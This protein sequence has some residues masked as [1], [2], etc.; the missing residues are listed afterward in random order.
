MIHMGLLNVLINRLETS[1][2]G[3]KEIHNTDGGKSRT[4]SARAQEDEDMEIIFPKRVKME[5]SPPRYIPVQKK[6]H[7]LNVANDI[8]KFKSIKLN[9]IF[10]FL[11]WHWLA[12]DVNKQRFDLSIAM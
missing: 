6:L 7:S 10:L 8:T 2:K 4:A 12:N 11:A 9:V 1:I 3:V 5:F